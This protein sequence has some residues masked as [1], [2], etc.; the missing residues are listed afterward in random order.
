M[1]IRK[2][3]IKNLGIKE[4][5][6]VNQL[7][8]NKIG[9]IKLAFVR[10][11]INPMIIRNNAANEVN[12]FNAP[13]G[14]ELVEIPA[15]KLKSKEKRLG[16]MICRSR[17]V[18][19][20]KVRYNSIFDVAQLANPN[21][22]LFGDS[23]TQSDGGALV[24]RVVYDWAYSLRDV[25]T[26]S[27]VITKDLQHNSTSEDS[28][29]LKVRDVEIKAKEESGKK[30]APQALHSVKYVMPG[31]LFPHFVTID[32]T[33]PE[34]LMHLLYCI[35]NEHKYG[36]QTTTMGSNM[37]NHLVGIAFSDFEKPM[38]SYTIS[39]DW[40]AK[41]NADKE[42]KQAATVD[43]LTAFI[44][45]EIA[46]HYGKGFNDNVKG[47]TDWLE[48]FWEKEE[49]TKTAYNQAKKDAETYLK[50]LKMIKS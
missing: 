4:S 17:N 39:R 36:A 50:A 23:V 33:T 7:I 22:V 31:T 12:T 14:R 13:D 26:Q 30:V 6:F 47:I 27:E 34:L 37:N 46:K 28:T 9:I 11:V 2:E 15:R 49:S 21:S 10:E 8:D 20:E 44:K 1:D 24:S 41:Q 25:D 16:L 29:I 42:K 32:N 5:Y 35:L 48:G 18:V 40:Y 45:V 38:N 43:N 19:D 3:I